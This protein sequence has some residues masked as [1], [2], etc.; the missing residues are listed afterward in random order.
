MKGE[1]V[2]QGRGTWRWSSLW[3]GLAV[4]TMLV[5]SA[6]GGGAAPTATTAPKAVDPTKPS[7]AATTAPA[8][9]ATK[10]AAAAQPVE[11]ANKAELAQLQG[12]IVIDGSS[13][14][15]PVTSAAAQD[16]TQY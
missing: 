9:A 10:P 15:F 7:A 11:P 8:A 12:E 4:M 16:F 13:T 3:L 6:C 2:K 14:V 5:L 1:T